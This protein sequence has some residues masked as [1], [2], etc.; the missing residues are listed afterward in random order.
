MRILVTGGAGFIG[1]ELVRRLVVN[2]HH[3]AVTVHTHKPTVEGVETYEIDV[4]DTRKT[5]IVV[6]EFNPDVIV[7]AAAMSDAD[8]CERSPDE[9]HEV[10]V[11]G[12][13]NVIAANDG[14]DA[15]I[16]FLSSSFV[17]SGEKEFCEETG[18]RSPINVYGETKVA[19]EDIVND[20]IYSSTIIRTDQPYG[21][22]EPWQESDMVAWTVDQL[23]QPGTVEVFKEWWNN[24][25]YLPDLVESIRVLIEECRE[26]IF[27][28]VG[29]D[30][31][32]RFQWAVEI[33]R[34]FGYD[35]DRI[36]PISTAEA[37]LPAVRPNVRLSPDKLERCIESKIRPV[38]DGVKRMRELTV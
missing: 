10:N 38:R 27:H 1:H 12:T 16:I 31:I 17:F 21:W 2:G 33:A 9:A 3:I 8:V 18:N 24:P 35:Q 29:P 34:V 25:I 19:A 23:K 22:P 30:F 20:S 13:K 5:R 6:T 7:H 36:V 37:D 32:N 14:I 28:A 11:G 26:G 15:H 4:R